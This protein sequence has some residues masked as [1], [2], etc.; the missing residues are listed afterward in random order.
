MQVSIPTISIEKF[1]EYH[2]EIRMHTINVALSADLNDREYM[3]S[4][5]L[6]PENVMVMTL[7]KLLHP[8][9]VTLMKCMILKYLTKINHSPCS[10]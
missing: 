7:K 4:E 6:D 3:E 5:L 9:I 10:I 1:L 8:N 2:S